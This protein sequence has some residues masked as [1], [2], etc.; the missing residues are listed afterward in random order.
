MEIL[1]QQKE[2]KNKYLDLKRQ[3]HE[4][5]EER[6]FIIYEKNSN[7]DIPKISQIK[8]QIAKVKRKLYLDRTQHEKVERYYD[9]AM[10]AIE[11][12]IN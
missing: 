10:L 9:M 5:E 3:E 12:I 2:L 7:L 11:N 1:N 4:A 6:V 8:E